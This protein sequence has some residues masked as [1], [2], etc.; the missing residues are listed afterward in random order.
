MKPCIP[1]NPTTRRS[2]ANMAVLGLAFLVLSTQVP[3][4][5]S[6]LFLCIG[7]VAVLEDIW[8]A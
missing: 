3:V 1:G 5:F 7:I 4:P 2:H 8:D 6:Y